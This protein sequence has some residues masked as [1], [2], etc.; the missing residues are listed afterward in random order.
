MCGALFNRS[1]SEEKVMAVDLSGSAALSLL[2]LEGLWGTF[3]CLT[4][5]QRHTSCLAR[6]TVRLEDPVS[7]RK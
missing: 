1:L 6:T 2:V 4:V 7:I 3:L 5:A